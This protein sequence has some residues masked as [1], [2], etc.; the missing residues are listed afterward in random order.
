M[1]WFKVLLLKVFRSAI[2]QLIQEVLH[3][4]IAELNEEIDEAFTDEKERTT[5]KSGILMLRTRVS[6]AIQERF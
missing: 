3:K 5:L 2:D 4:A 6:S 1:N